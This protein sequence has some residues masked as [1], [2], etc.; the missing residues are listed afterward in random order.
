[1]SAV[2]ELEQVVSSL[3]REELAEFR[4]WFREYDADAW[5]KEIEEDALASRLDPL[6]EEALVEHREGRTRPL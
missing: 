5:D 6:I 3:S 2:K 1:V 4:R